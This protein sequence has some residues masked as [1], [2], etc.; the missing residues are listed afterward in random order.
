MVSGLRA[1]YAAGALPRLSDPAEVDAQL[2]R[3]IQTDWVVYTKPWLSHSEAVVDYLARYSHRIAISDRRILGID[4]GE[5]A[6]RY[7]DY[8]D[9]NRGKVMKLQGEELIRR[10][11]LHVLPKGLSPFLHI[12]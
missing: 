2:D 10:Y 12:L 1:A 8:P 11:L 6:V 4:N 5:V 7:K 9:G 3:L